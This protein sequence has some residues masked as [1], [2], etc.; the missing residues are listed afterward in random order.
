MQRRNEVK[1]VIWIAAVREG[2][3]EQADL[4]YYN[5]Y[6]VSSTDNPLSRAGRWI[7]ERDAELQFDNWDDQRDS[8]A[9]QMLEQRRQGEDI[10]G[11]VGDV[12]LDWWTGTHDICVSALRNL[13]INRWI[14]EIERKPPPRHRSRPAELDCFE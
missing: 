8:F 14:T 6:F 1:T 3:T 4:Y 5:D 2:M 10:R 13:P 12:Q 9:H 11:L 7:S